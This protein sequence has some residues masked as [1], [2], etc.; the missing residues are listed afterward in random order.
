MMKGQEC[1]IPGFLGLPVCIGHPG[2]YA[3]CFISISGS[4]PLVLRTESSL[5]QS[6]LT[7]TPVPA[8]WIIFHN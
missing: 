8:P 7:T 5:D 4:S 6:E 1:S 3:S 2:L